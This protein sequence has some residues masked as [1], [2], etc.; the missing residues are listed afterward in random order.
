MQNLTG[1]WRHLQSTCTPT[2]KYKTPASNLFFPVY[3]LTTSKYSKERN[4]AL[5]ITV[6]IE[7]IKCG[8]IEY[9]FNFGFVRC[10][11]IDFWIERLGK[12]NSEWDKDPFY[13]Q[14]IHYFD[15]HFYLYLSR[16]FL[17]RG[18]LKCLSA[19]Q[20][21]VKAVRRKISWHWKQLMDK[22]R[23][24]LEVTMFNLS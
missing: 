14:T 21:D 10:F 15:I 12:D 6:R 5:S 2:M 22:V 20:T 7:Y 11:Q 1:R 3:V 24:P 8:T 9:W 23:I 17:W 16:H 18:F 13:S 19:R 4:N